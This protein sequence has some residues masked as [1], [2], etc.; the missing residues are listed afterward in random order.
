MIVQCQSWLDLY[1]DGK[2]RI[3]FIQCRRERHHEGN[4]SANAFHDD[5]MLTDTESSNSVV[6]RLDW[7]LNDGVVYQ[8]WPKK[9]VA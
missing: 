2:H 5:A 1:M 3:Q 9:E 7:R 4:H 8:R 6:F